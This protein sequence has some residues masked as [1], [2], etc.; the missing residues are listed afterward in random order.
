M[1]L[2]H[3]HTL[4]RTEVRDEEGYEFESI[5]VARA[6]AVT[7]ASEVLKELGDAIYDTDLR[8]T[9]TD[10]DGL[11]LWDIVVVA[12]EAP[13]LAPPALKRVL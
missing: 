1:S 4:D 6:A 10:G 7:Y 8:V 9:V 13:A 3:F 12:T 11:I 2:Y 5:A